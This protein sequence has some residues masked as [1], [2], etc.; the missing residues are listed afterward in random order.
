M[1]TKIIYCIACRN[2]EQ[3]ELSKAELSLLH[4]EALRKLFPWLFEQESPT[5]LPTLCSQC[6]YKI[7]KGEA[8]IMLPDG[9]KSELF[10]LRSE[11]IKGLIQQAGR[12][13]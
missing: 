1:P 7:K 4:T 3:K 8:I 5:T 11:N 6:A 10:Q 2:T 13:R 9:F 12:K